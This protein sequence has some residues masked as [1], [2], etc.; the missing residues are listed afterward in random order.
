VENV[1]LLGFLF[2]SFLVFYKK[3]K[4]IKKLILFF[5]FFIFFKF[6]WSQP[7]TTARLTVL[8]GNQVVFNFN[9]LSKIENGIILN[10]WTQLKIEY[11]DSTASGAEGTGWELDVRTNGTYLVSEYGAVTSFTPEYIQLTTS[12]S[13]IGNTANIVTDH[14]L[15][16]SDTPIATYN[17]G[18]VIGLK[19][20]VTIT[21]KCGTSG[22]LI[23]LESNY[24]STDLVFT[25]KAQ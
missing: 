5:V 9:L 22:Q 3:I 6:T 4:V 24:F 23:G 20:I 19:G 7:Y 16:S 15:S 12:Y 8:T 13:G 1:V 10:D 11:T 25:L 14:D 2:I 18:S 21:Y 17:S